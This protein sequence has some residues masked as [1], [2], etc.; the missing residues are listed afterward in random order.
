MHLYLAGAYNAGM[1]HDSSAAYS[2]LT[3]MKKSR[4]AALPYLLES[5]HYLKKDKKSCTALKC[6]GKTIFLDSGAYSAW[7]KGV[8]IDIEE[9]ARFQKEHADIIHMASVLDSIGD[10][11]QTWLNQKR[12]EALGCEVLPCYHYGEPLE[13]GHY[14]AENYP[15]ITL[16]GMVGRGN[17]PLETWL[18]E[19]FT[20]V[21]CDSDGYAKCKVHGFGLTSVPLMTRYPWYS[22]D[23]TSWVMTASYGSLVFPELKRP[24]SISTK[25]P[26]RKDLGQ[27]FSTMT[28]REQD[29]IR[30]LSARYELDLDAAAL[31]FAPR[32]AMNLYAFHLMGESMGEDHWR[33]PFLH[34]QRRLF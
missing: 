26:S 33:K 4:L 18:D 12:L 8:T 22:V 17:G 31:D 21:I 16:G 34:R 14:Y 3:T 6:R 5:Y 13:V 30:E 20:E 32:Y 9:Y 23:S 1:M 11:D 19:V 29:Y 24:V 15:Y 27:H 10:P 28:K 7:T 2:R 25:S